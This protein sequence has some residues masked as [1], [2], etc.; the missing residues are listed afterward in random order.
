[1]RHLLPPLANLA[2]AFIAAAIVLAISGIAPGPA[3]LTMLD[4]A[5]GSSD[6]IGYTLYYATSFIFAGL[7][8]A[9]PLQAGLFN[10]GG[11]GQAMMGG[12]PL[13]LICLALPGWPW[14]VVLPLAALGGMLG[15]AAWGFLP[16]LL[17]VRRG[18]HVVITTIL[19]NFIAAS[20]LTWLL[21]GPLREPGDPNP[22]TRAFDAA[23]TLPSWPGTPLNVSFILALALAS[24]AWLMLK[25]SVWGY[26][27]RAT[28]LNPEAARY[29]AIPTGR[30]AIAALCLGG[31]CAG[32]IGIN[33]AMGVEHRLVMNFTAGAG[34]VGIAVALMGRSHPIGIVLAALLFGALYQGGTEL[35]FD[36]P[37]VTRDIVVVIQGLVILVCGGLEHLMRRP[38]GLFRRAPA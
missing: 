2:V 6:G 28:G 15:G 11:E 7:A 10:I 33:E 1:M 18:S 16:A 35:S 31:A 27:L 34:F 24:L 14:W 30:V 13:A 8:V 32:L 4:G 23:M 38:T 19:M 17:Q 36:Y 25:R 20:L 3:L 26:E 12:I 9:I 37:N 29:A 22:E 5:L 21:V